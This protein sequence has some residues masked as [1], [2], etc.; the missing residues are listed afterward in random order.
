MVGSLE[1]VRKSTGN[2]AGY[3]EDTPLFYNTIFSTLIQV[4]FEYGKFRVGH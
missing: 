2:I 1:M 4:N 3:L